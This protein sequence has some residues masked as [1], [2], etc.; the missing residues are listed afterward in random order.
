MDKKEKKVDNRELRRLFQKVNAEMD[1]ARK[2]DL[3]DGGRELLRHIG[4][5][6][7]ELLNRTEGMP[8]LPRQSMMRSLEQ[9]TEHFER[10]H[11]ALTMALS[12]LLTALSNA[13][14]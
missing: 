10:T 11:P 3:D 7:N 2:A 12:E 4:R 14:I 6:I 5:D 1:Q 13:G 8:L 9:A